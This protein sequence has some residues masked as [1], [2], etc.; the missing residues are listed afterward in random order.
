MAADILKGDAQNNIIN[1]AAGD[2]TIYG[3]DG[4]DILIGGTG[5]DTLDGGNG[6]NTVDYSQASKGIIAQLDRGIVLTPIYETLKKPKILPLGDSITAGKH[7][8]DPNPGAYRIQ[9]WKNFSADGLTIDFVGSGSNGPDRLGDKDHEGH[10]GWTI[11]QITD[12][13]DSGLLKTY[14]PDI[15]LLAIGTNDT[16]RSPNKMSADLSNLI[17]RITEQLPKTQ[18]LVSSIAPEDPNGSR[19]G[20][21]KV[22]TTRA[23]NAKNFNA[24]IP[25]LV[26]NKV[27]QGKKV[28]FADVGG[29]LTVED[30]VSDGIHPNAE[31]Y[32]K[33]GDKWY[34]ALVERD[35]LINIENVVGTRYRDSFIGNVGSNVF[36]GGGSKDIFT[37][38]GGAD[39]FVYRNPSEGGDTITDFAWNDFFNISA[40][41][42]GGGLADG[43]SLSLTDAMTG[44]FVSGSNPTP[45]G[46]NATFLYDTG[47]GLLSFDRD[48]IGSNSVLKLAT[49]S[50]SPSLSFEQFKIVA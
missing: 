22:G 30:L 20:S 41:G 19:K 7:A 6:I 29:S 4:N 14:Q 2:N 39:T 44:V 21:T 15:V 13:V 17:D 49:L 48:G 26:N 47:T 16:G 3:E 50:N 46:T 43:V 11:G 37:G 40:A 8:V 9:L 34:E 5:K 42:F 24:L 38:G 25:D 12:L 32:N 33:M 28:A 35:T 10:P 27:N 18:I 31:G 45:I 1:G 23:N 36:E